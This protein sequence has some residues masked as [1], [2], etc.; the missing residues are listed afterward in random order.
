[1]RPDDTQCEAAYR[2]ALLELEADGKIEVLG[3]DG[4]N[5]TGVESRPKRKGKPTLA[6]EYFVRLR[7]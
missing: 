3:K 1:M 2:Q 7:K 4:K 6:K 5:V